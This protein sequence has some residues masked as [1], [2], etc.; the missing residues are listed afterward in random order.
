MHYHYHYHYFRCGGIAEL[1][2]Y[3]VISTYIVGVNR[4]SVH[5]VEEKPIPKWFFCQTNK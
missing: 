5:C 3:I 1:K 4:S 2:D